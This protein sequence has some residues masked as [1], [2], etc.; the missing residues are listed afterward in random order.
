MIADYQ[1]HIAAAEI[2]PW[3]PGDR[4]KLLAGKTLLRQGWFRACKT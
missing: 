2:R 3:R 4:P 1:S